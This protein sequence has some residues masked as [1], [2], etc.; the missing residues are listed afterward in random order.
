[1]TPDEEEKPWQ[2]IRLTTLEKVAFSTFA[3]C[4]AGIVAILAWVIL[5]FI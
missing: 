4:A 1:M 2:N 3:I 5:S